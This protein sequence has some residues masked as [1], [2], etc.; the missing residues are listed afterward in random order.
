MSHAVLPQLV[1][2]SRT[3]VSRAGLLALALF[4]ALTADIAAVNSSLS[5]ADTQRALKVAGATEA[6]RARFHA[7]YRVD[8]RT[9]LVQGL[10]VLT[11]FRRTVSAAED[12]FRRGDWAVAHGA[13]SLGGRGI[14]EIVGPW[15]RKVTIVAT[16]QLDPLHTYVR[17]P[18]CEVMM[19]G[20]PVLASLDRR[21]IPLSSQPYS[22]RGVMTTSLLGATIEADFD[23]EAVGRT[24]R[25]AV[26]ICEGRDAARVD[27]DFSGIE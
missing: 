7:A 12:A 17:F 22:S 26:V 16:L 19:G 9:S 13:R 5:P 4:V 25:S 6:V 2:R 1:R 27:I 18:N 24:A 8:V 10:E 3:P 21:T 23:A 11:E 15:K 20:M 14:A